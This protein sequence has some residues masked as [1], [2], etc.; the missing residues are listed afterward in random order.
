ML[1]EQQKRELEWSRQMR[2]VGQNNEK[3][4]DEQNFNDD[5]DEQERMR[6][7]QKRR[8]ISLK[9]QAK[10]K[11][12]NEVKKIAKKEFKKTFLKLLV[13]PAFWIGVGYVLL[14]L[15]VLLIIFVVAYLINNPCEAVQYIGTWWASL[16][17]V[18]CEIGG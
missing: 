9:K 3:N 12:K 14:G 1:D 15:L 16:F 6:E 8:R 10:E 4:K 2:N 13:N 5:G 7:M 11:A 17:G 18:I